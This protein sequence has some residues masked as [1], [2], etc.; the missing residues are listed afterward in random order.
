MRT[1]FFRYQNLIL[2]LVLFL[3]LMLCSVCDGFIAAASVREESL[4]LH[5]LA[6]SDSEEDQSVKLLV[7][8]A[9]LQST[10]EIFED[11]INADA[12]AEKVLENKLYL[13]SIANTVLEEN[14]FSYKA[15]VS[16]EDEYFETRQYDNVKLPAGRYKAC[17]VVLGEGEGKNWWCI[18]FPPLCLPAVT[19]KTDES[20][21][22]VYGE[23]GGN[24]VTEKSGYKIK[25]RIVEIVEEIIEKINHNLTDKV[26]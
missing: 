21:Y 6:A 25:F 11:S 22:A 23:N 26:H 9:L 12:A 5:V 18:M 7:R 20:V 3:S 16:I 10:E 4:R 15:T 17:K 19:E 8:D 14:G 1:Y 2:S 24:L 13:E